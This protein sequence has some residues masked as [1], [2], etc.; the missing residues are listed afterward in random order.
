MKRFKLK[1]VGLSAVCVLS[2]LGYVQ[3]N[4]SEKLD[5]L[6][7]ENIE[8]LAADESVTRVV[9]IGSGSIV[10]PIIEQ[11]VEH[12]RIFYTQSR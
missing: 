4:H 5:D 12:V 8:A 2:V 1:L 9:C 7:L 6:L 3:M 10:C 11:E